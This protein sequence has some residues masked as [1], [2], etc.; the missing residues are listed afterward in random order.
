MIAYVHDTLISAV[1][2]DAEARDAAKAIAEY[3]FA[4]ATD[5]P[6]PFGMFVSGNCLNVTSCLLI[7]AERNRD[8]IRRWLVRAKVDRT[9]DGLQVDP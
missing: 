1:A 8:P 7:L 6:A 9:G 5:N 4:K 3:N 2:D